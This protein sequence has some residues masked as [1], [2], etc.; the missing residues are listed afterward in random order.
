MQSA[1]LY[2]KEGQQKE[3]LQLDERLFGQK[4]NVSVMHQ[5][6]KAYLANQRQGTVKKKNRTEVR[7]GGAKPWRQ[8]GTGRSRSGS[9]ASPI[10]VGGGRAFAPVPRDYR[11]EIPKKM[12]R[13]A[14]LSSLSAVALENRVKIIEDLSLEVPKTKVVAE[15]LGRLGIA[16]SKV[17]LLTEGK[18][19]NLSKSCRNLKDLVHKRARLVSPYDLLICD[20]L[21]VT[22]KALDNLTEVFAG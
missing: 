12:K 19:D 3:T 5:Y 22:Q 15:L 21:V 20:Y 1:V 2:D 8:K 4:P 17:L 10:W 11:T 14:L 6:V 18:E 9:N 7:G 13:M 16:G